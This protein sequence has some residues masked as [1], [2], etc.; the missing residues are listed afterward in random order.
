MQ[1]PDPSAL[2]GQIG[3][4]PEGPG[5]RQAMVKTLNDYSPLDSPTVSTSQVYSEN[6]GFFNKIT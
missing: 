4:D 3:K 1:T 2:T 5:R 6:I